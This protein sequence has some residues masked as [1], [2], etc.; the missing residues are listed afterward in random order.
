MATIKAWWDPIDNITFVF[1]HTGYD[2]KQG[3]E[4]A[5]YV[6]WEDWKKAGPLVSSLPP[7]LKIKQL[8]RLGYQVFTSYPAD[9]DE[10]LKITPVDPNLGGKTF[11]GPLSL[12]H[13]QRF[14]VEGTP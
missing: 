13:L 11:V 10:W 1:L 4:V 6:T 5:H 12:E 3:G 9:V 7:P 8:I 2:K 14:R